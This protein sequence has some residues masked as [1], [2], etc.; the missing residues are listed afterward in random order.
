M[1]YVLIAAGMLVF[2][3]GALV[4]I[5]WDS[6]AESYAEIVATTAE[7]ATESG[8]QMGQT[9]YHLAQ[10][11]RPGYMTDLRDSMARLDQVST[12]FRAHMMAGFEAG[13][14]VARKAEVDYTEAY[15][16]RLLSEAEGI[17]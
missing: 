14:E 3:A 11:G 1:R 17:D 8:S 5:K 16:E 2:M 9:A 12:E 6:I 13:L 10:C 4:V 7:L 15:C